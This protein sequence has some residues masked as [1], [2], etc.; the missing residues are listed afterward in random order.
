M[1]D[2]ELLAAIGE[3]IDQ[4]L[5]TVNDSLVSIDGRL[6]TLETG[7]QRVEAIVKDT[8]DTNRKTHKRLFAQLDEMWKDINKNERRVDRLEQKAGL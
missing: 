4:K 1:P 7:Q 2:E 3:M 8:R 5:K 6:T